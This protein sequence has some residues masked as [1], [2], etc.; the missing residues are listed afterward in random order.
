MR[1]K[2][3]IVLLIVVLVLV[4]IIVVCG[5]TF[6]VRHVEAYSYYENPQ[7]EQ[8]DKNVIAASGIKTN[9][10]MFFVDEEEVKQRIEKAYP[11]IGVVNVK[12]GFPDRVTINY[13]IYEKLYQF[14]SGGKYYQCYSSGK[15]GSE[16]DTLLQGY[17]TVKP[18]GATSITVG[19]YFQDNN[20][21]DRWYVDTIIA[22]LR[23][24]GM[25]DYQIRERIGFIDLRR[26]GYVYIRTNDGCSIEIHDNGGDFNA[27]LDR[28]FAVYAKTDPSFTDVVK[29][30]GL[31]KVYPNL[32][33]GAEDPIRC[34]Y[35]KHNAAQDGDEI[36]TDDGYYARHYE[37]VDNVPNA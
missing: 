33:A 13:V 8:Y 3:L 31:I 4:T 5:A 32:S 14:Q 16:S 6:L 11:E 22:F 24:K 12:R 23:S 9:S 10:S 29:V 27:M 7:I 25:L 2:K 28:G 36:Y 1:N 19:N 17:F 21:R 35:L 30:S 34:V 18:A 37:A 20:G 15:I 26:A